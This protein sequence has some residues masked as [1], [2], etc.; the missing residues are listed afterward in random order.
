MSAQ[1]D[2][3]FQTTGTNPTGTIISFFGLAAPEGYLACDGTT[4]NIADY[5]G[6]A[7][8]ILANFGKYN[9]FG[10]D[11]SATFAVPNL[12][13]EFLRGAGTNGHSKQGAGASVGVHQDSTITPK[14]STNTYGFFPSYIPD[15]MDRNFDSM[16]YT[17]NGNYYSIT[18]AHKDG[19]EAS[20]GVHTIRP[21]NTSVL[22]C[23]KT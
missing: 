22:Y 19:K 2:L 23:I 8:F 7:T 12:Q 18:A 20:H 4:Y 10:G 21:T 1:I 16:T 5:E 6:L 15:S 14:F 13:G 3:T 17:N 9:Y 11:G